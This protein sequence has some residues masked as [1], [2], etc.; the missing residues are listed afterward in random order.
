MDPRISGA[1]NSVAR[2]GNVGF[3]LV[4]GL[5]ILLHVMFRLLQGLVLVR[6]LLVGR[7]VVHRGE[8]ASTLAVLHVILQSLA[9]ILGVTSQSQ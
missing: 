4:V 7:S 3:M 2:L 5:V 9:L 6:S 8:I 1:I